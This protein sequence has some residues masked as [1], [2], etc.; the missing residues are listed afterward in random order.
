MS[1]KKCVSFRVSVPSLGFS[2]LGNYVLKRIS[3]MCDLEENLE[4]DLQSMD[5]FFGIHL[6]FLGGPFGAHLGSI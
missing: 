4:A 2:F 1:R 6:A 3:L 5:G